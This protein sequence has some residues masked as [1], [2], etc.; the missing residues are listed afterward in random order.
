M[1]LKI[2]QLEKPHSNFRQDYLNKVDLGYRKMS[3]SSV[4]ICSTVRDCARRLEKNIPKIE[5]L[6]VCFQDSIVVAIENDSIDGT[7]DV[8]THWKESEA[9]ITVISNDYGIDTIVET[10]DGVDASFSDHRIGRM[11]FYRNQY[12]RELKDKKNIDYVIVVD[13]DLGDISIDGIANT[14]GQSNTWHA[15]AANGLNHYP[16]SEL[17]NS[18]KYFDTYAFCEIGDERPR[19][20]R[21]IFEYQKL[22]QYLRPGMLMMPVSSA[23]GGLVV[24][25]YHALLSAEY[26]VLT[27]DDNEVG[28]QCEHIALHRKMRAEGFDKIFIN[29]SQVVLYETYLEHLAKLIKKHTGLS[30]N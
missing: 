16:F 8:L 3:K 6:R 23:F 22:L 19:T 29:P 2:K 17:T 12:M 21:I 11:A 1:S 7:K 4:A 5:K 18:Y 20:K 13:L 30:K 25:D 14:F 9:G 10:D 26:D 27:N 15:V 28:V 24:Y